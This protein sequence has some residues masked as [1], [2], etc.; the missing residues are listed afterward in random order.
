M[1]QK[2]RKLGE[3]GKVH[4]CRTDCRT[5]RNTPDKNSGD[6]DFGFHNAVNN[7]HEM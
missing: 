7:I 1:E 4:G 6:V 2:N 3:K 5:A